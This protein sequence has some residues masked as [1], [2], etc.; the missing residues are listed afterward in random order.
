MIILHL[1]NPENSFFFFSFFYQ[2]KSS[3]KNKMKEKLAYFNY[4]A[5]FSFNKSKHLKTRCTFSFLSRGII[6]WIEL[7]CPENPASDIQKHWTAVS[8]LL[9]L[10]SSIYRDLPHWRSNQWPQNAE[11][12]LY[13]WATRSKQ[14]SS[15]S[16]CHAQAFTGFSDH[17]NKLLI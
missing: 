5:N 16:L 10:I 8:T 17:G 15:V 14:L 2:V 13:Y 1:R 11:P 6:L 9:G 12:K 7:P 3:N 4:N